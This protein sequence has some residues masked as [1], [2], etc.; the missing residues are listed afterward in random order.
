MESFEDLHSENETGGRDMLRWVGGVFALLALGLAAYLGVLSM[1]TGKLPPGCGSGSG[2]GTVLGSSWSAFYGVPVAWGAVAVYALLA[3]G[4]FSRSTRLVD[5]AASLVVGSVCWFVG[6]Q[7]FILKAF[8]LYCLAD[9]AIGLLAAVMGALACGGKQVN[10]WHGI[11]LAMTI[12]FALLQFTQPTKLYLLS[13]DLSGD[14]DEQTAEGRRLA[15]LSGAL[16][17][18]LS[19]H[20][21]TG[22]AE[23]EQVWAVMLD[24]ACPH[25]RAVHH[26]L[27]TYVAKHPTRLAFVSLPT[28]IHPSCN[29]HIFEAPERFKDSCALARLSMGLFHLKPS[30]WAE[31]D[32]WLFETE[33]PRRLEDAQRQLR[34]SHGIEPEAASAHP[35][36]ARDLLMHLAA[37][38][39][40]PVN[41]PS[42][43]RVPVVLR[44][45][46]P[47]V[48]GPIEEIDALLAPL[49]TP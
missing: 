13:H 47:I 32:A 7:V 8:C 27:S 42:E 14:A 2:C 16:K 23:A 19:R 44:P 38:G 17:L 45:N 24:Y 35:L 31:Y 29:P 9:H 48:L 15:L 37:F 10:R 28:P 43:R 40:L 36:A 22:S 3:F 21:L 5:L 20:P 11:G 33:A 6:V 1:S 41:D 12:A 30:A 39:A 26:T 25:C 46:K 4:I 18:E 34:E 49:P